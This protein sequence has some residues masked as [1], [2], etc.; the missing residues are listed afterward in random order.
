MHGES[1]SRSIASQEGSLLFLRLT[2][3]IATIDAVDVDVDELIVSDD[4]LYDCESN[5]CGADF[6]CDNNGC[7]IVGPFVVGERNLAFLPG[8]VSLLVTQFN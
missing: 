5:V 4:V 2:W 8:T 7:D 1:K 6:E 3:L